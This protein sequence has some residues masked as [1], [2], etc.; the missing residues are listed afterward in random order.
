MIHRGKGY[1][2]VIMRPLKIILSPVNFHSRHV[3]YILSMTP[4]IFQ[5][6]K[7]RA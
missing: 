4:E 6:G 5:L 2:S 1:G 7:G 3:L